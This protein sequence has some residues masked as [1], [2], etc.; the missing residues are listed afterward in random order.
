MENRVKVEVSRKKK[1]KA[2]FTFELQ[3]LFG[4]VRNVFVVKL[5]ETNHFRTHETERIIRDYM[6]R[7][8]QKKLEAAE[9]LRRRTL[10]Q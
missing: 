2:N 5:P 8:E 9:F 10:I 4:I 3:K 7:A 1:V 6:M